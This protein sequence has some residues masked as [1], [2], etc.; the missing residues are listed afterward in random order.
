MRRLRHG[1]GLR[2]PLG[3]CGAGDL[4]DAAARRLRQR[5]LSG[6]GLTC[7]PWRRQ[8]EWW[9]CCFGRHC[10]AAPNAS[11]VLGRRC[12]RG[13]V[14]GPRGVVLGQ[15]AAFFLIGHSYCRGCTCNAEPW[16]EAAAPRGVPRAGGLRAA[17]AAGGLDAGGTR[18]DAAEPQQAAEVPVASAARRCGVVIIVQGAGRTEARGG[19]SRTSSDLRLCQRDAREGRRLRDA[20]G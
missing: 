13:S 18:V 6:G 1:G 19:V 7:W 9:L 16:A 5:R 20:R 8:R 3:L 2:R 15:R 12:R 10:A 11:P 17:A 14:A 4:P